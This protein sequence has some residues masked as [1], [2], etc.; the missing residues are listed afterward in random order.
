METTGDNVELG[1]QGGAS[2]RHE[3]GDDVDWDSEDAAAFMARQRKFHFVMS[4][5][6]MYLGMLITNWGYETSS[7]DASWNGGNAS[8]WVK[9][10]SLWVTV[11][12]YTWSLLKDTIPWC[13]ERC[14]NSDDEDY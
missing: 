5:A 11:A 9:I 4:F 8:T 13:A 1:T 2:E 3:A 6:S 7:S 12:L 10:I 14:G